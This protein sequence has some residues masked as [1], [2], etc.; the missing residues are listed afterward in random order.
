MAPCVTIGCGGHP[1]VNVVR[2][3]IDASLCAFNN[4]VH[5]H[6]DLQLQPLDRTMWVHDGHLRYLVNTDSDNAVHPLSV[7]AVIVSFRCRSASARPWFGSA[8]NGWD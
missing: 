1:N 6:P 7:E 4:Y 8:Y 5:A 2:I 3:H